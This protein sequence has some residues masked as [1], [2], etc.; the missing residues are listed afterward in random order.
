MMIASVRGALGLTPVF[1]CSLTKCYSTDGQG[2]SA[3]THLL[4][5]NLQRTIN[6][7]AA[8]AGFKAVTVDGFIGSGTASAFTKAAN[9]AMQRLNAMAVDGSWGAAPAA[10]AARTQVATVVGLGASK[11]GL[12]A[13][14]QQAYDALK[15][16]ADTI[17]LGIWT[18]TPLPPSDVQMPPF[19]VPPYTPPTPPTVPPPSM[20]P[21]T[22]PPPPMQP[23]WT[24][25]NWPWLAA[26]AILLA[27]LGTAT[28]YVFKPQ[29]M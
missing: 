7:Y 13:G 8:N 26:G 20:Q 22:V 14:A 10:I 23:S 25:T 4:F 5:L 27:G 15:F 1:K 16:A 18:Q 6:R 17:G 28:Y 29:E 21:P 12:A 9:Y 24:R 3:G 11:Q 19:Q 2:T